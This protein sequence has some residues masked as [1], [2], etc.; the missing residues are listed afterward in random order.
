MRRTQYNYAKVI[1]RCF[2]CGAPAYENHHVVP[3]ALGGTKTVPLCYTCHDKIHDLH[4]VKAIS[5]ARATK[6]RIREAKGR[7][8]G[9]HGYH[10]TPEGQAL[11]EYVKLLRSRDDNGK[12]LTLQQ[13]ADR[14]NAE[15]VT[16]L[17]GHR[18]TLYRVD[19]VLRYRIT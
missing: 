9:R 14:L 18:W 19:H 6:Q 7:C 16:T 17:T 2:E 15:G 8:E 12:Q 13:V 10:D 1:G 5:L 3:V 11:Y 4:R